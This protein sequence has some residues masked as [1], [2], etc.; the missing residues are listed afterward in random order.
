MRFGRRGGK[1]R[2]RDP[3]W[4]RKESSKPSET[5]VIELSVEGSSAPAVEVLDDDRDAA[6]QEVMIHLG[7]FSR[8]CS[9]PEKALWSD[10]CM[11]QLIMCTEIAVEQGWSELTSVLS[12]TAR[13]LHTYENAQCPEQAVEF[14]QHAYEILCQLVGDIV[15]EK[16][17]RETMG[18]WSSIHVAAIDVLSERGL[19]LFDDAADTA[20]EQPKPI[21]TEV[22]AVEAVDDVGEESAAEQDEALFEDFTTSTVAEV[23]LVTDDSEPEP[24]PALDPLPPLGAL[25]ET[26]EASEVIDHSDIAQDNASFASFEMPHLEPLP[27]DIPEAARDES[28]HSD[29]TASDTLSALTDV[30]DDALEDLGELESPSAIEVDEVNDEEIV[31]VEEVYDPPRIVVDIIDRI[32]DVIGQIEQADEDLRTEHIR[33]LSGGLEALAHE[34]KLMDTRRAEAMSELMMNALATVRAGKSENDGQFIEIAYAFCGIFIEALSDPDSENVNAWQRECENWLK[35]MAAI[36]SPL[37]PEAADDVA[38]K[39]TAPTILLFEPKAEATA[40]KQ[41]DLPAETVEINEAT[42]SDLQAI[43]E[44]IDHAAAS[45]SLLQAAQDAARKGNGDAAKTFALRAAAE[46]AK[47]EVQRAEETLRA[48]EIKHAE[49]VQGTQEAR[50][51]VKSC[52]ESVRDAETMAVESRVGHTDSQQE[53]SRV[54]ED[55]EELEAGVADLNQQIQDLQARRDEEVE[56]LSATVQT[57]EE[58]K[59]TEIQCHTE[60]EELKKLEDDSRLRLE[61]SRQHVKDKQRIVQSI[62]TEMERAREL[63][64]KQKVSLSDITQAIQQISGAAPGDTGTQDDGMLF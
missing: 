14:L 29:T 22:I 25:N 23:E 54:A 2:S 21:E 64:T 10:A 52:E 7:H 56:K 20:D 12:D 58:A 43:D 49:S 39:N 46:I 30:M 6:T 61:E 42:E 48:S 63:L 17:L 50:K 27:D 9:D 62:E 60:S 3:I 34:A 59:Q 40:A 57:L 31:A 11:N 4:T 41:E 36:E 19:T 15:I 45:Q 53:V 26:S 47:T 24:L 28:P 38:E 51:S 1:G 32:C 33:V 35:N 5:N 37:E 13:V 8:E 16:E 44:E 55:L 18:L